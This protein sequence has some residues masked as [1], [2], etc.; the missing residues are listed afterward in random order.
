MCAFWHPP[1]QRIAT[2]KVR[3]FWFEHEIK[4]R[5]AKAPFAVEK[6]VNLIPISS[7][8]VAGVSE[9]MLDKPPASH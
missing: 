1:L 8:I 4:F 9:D 5:P 3:Y 2:L 7:L 6:Q